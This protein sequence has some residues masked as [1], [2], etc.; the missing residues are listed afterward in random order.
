MV[1]GINNPRAEID[2]IDS[3]ILRLLNRRASI[4]LRVGAAKS[5]V[6]T[7]LCDPQREHEV[8]DRLTRENPGP[9]DET[10]VANIFQR[11]IDESLHL[12]QRNFQR[13]PQIDAASGP[14][15]E[16]IGRL[17]RVAFQGERGSFSEEAALG[18]LGADCRTVP[19]RTFDDL[20]RAI[21]EGKAD[22]ILSPLE[23]SLV[24]SVHRCYDL[25]LASSL[26][27]VA[28][29]VL[30]ISHFLIGPPNASFESL[31]TVE[32]HPVALAQCERFFAA[33]PDLIGVAADD[34]AGSVKRAIESGDA[35][36]AAI[37]G[38]R[39][40]AIYGGK[41]L[42]EHI[43]DHAENFTRFALLTNVPDERATGSKIS[44]IVRLK[45]EPGALH[46]AMRPFVRRGINLLKIESRPIKGM[47]SE[48]N[49][50]FDLQAPASESELRGALDEIK[51]QAAE[52]RFLGRYS[53]I[54]IERP[55]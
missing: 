37:G 2:S 48:F 1:E 42:R 51:E 26:S 11:I 40:A 33:H 29:A 25:L 52:V 6:D 8:I 45:H 22:Y 5:N 28:E 16:N 35:S 7:S 46:N 10:S 20:F 32:S 23:N 41:I 43:E 44:L 36:R 4:A 21:D 15:L 47:P 13:S 39:T 55:D 24:G 14:D 17:S 38:K 3:E 27:V 9:F 53:T 12:Q 54:S 18:I 49:F 34:T 31:K 30:P 50:Y 19:C